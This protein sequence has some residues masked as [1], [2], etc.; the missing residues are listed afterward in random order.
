[1]GEYRRLKT[2]DENVRL[3]LSIKNAIKH[4]A[5]ITFPHCAAR[6]KQPGA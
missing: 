6:R 3:K 5:R 4:F 1:M 2:F